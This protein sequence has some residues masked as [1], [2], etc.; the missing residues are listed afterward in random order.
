LREIDAA[1]AL[2]PQAPAWAGQ[3]AFYL[4]C[5]RLYDDALAEIDRALALD[6]L[7]VRFHQLRA[8][9]HFVQ[10][11]LDE[12]LE[13][14][15]FFMEGRD[16]GAEGPFRRGL[17][18]ALKGRWPQAWETVKWL[19]EQPRG[20]AWAH[21]LAAH[22]RFQRREYAPAIAALKQAEAQVAAEGR[23]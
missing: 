16:R 18:L 9:I 21:F 15:A 3:R 12:T 1:I 7:S 19:A 8:S 2:E 20:G 23:P 17:I 5:Q 13:D 4:F 10:F 6:A 11:R 14:L 22:L